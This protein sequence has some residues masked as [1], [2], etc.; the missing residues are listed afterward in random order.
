MFD[1]D[2]FVDRDEVAHLMMIDATLTAG[3]LSTQTAD[4]TL[5][6]EV[7]I[8]TSGSKQLHQSS[9]GYQDVEE[10]ADGTL[11]PEVD[12]NS[13]DTANETIDI[14]GRKLVALAYGPITDGTNGVGGAGTA[15]RDWIKT[16]YGP[17]GP[18]LDGRDEVALNGFVEHSN[19]SDATLFW[20][21][22]GVVW[23]NVVER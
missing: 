6:A 11:T 8:S 5:R 21:V 19:V 9:G 16:D 4:G 15:G 18:E 3:I 22:D 7:E 12:T 17:R 14:L 13:D 10:S 2:R 23:L 1:V 20:E